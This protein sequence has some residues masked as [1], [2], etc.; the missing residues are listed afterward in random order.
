MDIFTTIGNFFRKLFKLDGVRV[1]DDSSK[2]RHAVRYDPDINVG[3]TEMQI[4]ERTEE[5]LINEKPANRTK[6]YGRII[7]ENVFNFCNTA[8]II[9]VALLFIAGAGMYAFSSI[10]V[11]LNMA[12]GI[13][14]EIK[15]KHKVEKLSMVMESR[16]DVIRD[17]KHSD[18]PNKQLALDDIY[19]LHA[20]QQ[21]PVDSVIK[22]GVVEV[23][24]SIITGESIPVRKSAGDYVLGA[25]AVVSGEA[26]L[27]ADKVG[28][29]CYIEN[30]ARVARRVSKP[31]SNI[32]S[33]L[34]KIIKIISVF[35]FFLAGFLLISL[36]VTDAES[37][38][39]IESGANLS[40]IS[41]FQGV[42]ITI[43]AAIL[44]ML[45]IG[46]FLLTSTT[47][48]ASTIKFT[49]KNTI[50]QDLYSIEMIAMVDTLLLDKTGTI[51]D[52]KLEVIDS[53][54]YAEAKY[55][56]DAVFNTILLA[57]KDGNSTANA[58]KSHFIYA[59]SLEYKDFCAF[60]SARKFSAVTLAD[61]TTY[62][63]GAPDFV[64]VNN[65][66]LD[67]YVS[68]NAEQGRRTIALMEFDGDIESF[69]PENAK[70]VCALTLEDSLRGDVKETLDWFH[71]N[72]VNIKIVSGD[73][74][75][76]VSKI[77]EK[78]G[79]RNAE[80][81]LNCKGLSD[82]ELL[83]KV[84]ETT[85][86]GRVSPEQ[87]QLIVNGLQAKG[88]TVGMIGDGVND[89]QALKEADCSISFASANEVARNI[90]RI[91]LMD[92]NFKTLPSAVQEGRQVIS[93]IQKVSSLYIMK[94]IFVM[95]MVFMFT[96][97]TFITK[98]NNYPFDT[99]RMLL[100][101]FFVI[102]VPTFCF[103]LQPNKARATDHFLANIMR[104]SI[105]SAIGLILGVMFIFI[106]LG[107]FEGDM[108]TFAT[109]Q[110][111]STA[112][113]GLAAAGFVCLIIISMPPDWFR[114]GLTVF[115]IGLAGLAIWLDGLYAE[116]LDKWFGGTFLNIQLDLPAYNWML[117]GVCAAIAGVVSLL[118]RFLVDWINKKYGEQ[119]YVAVENFNAKLKDI[120]LSAKNK[121][122]ALIKKQK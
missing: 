36:L 109:M 40:E 24:E 43:S 76:T 84:D 72:D 107:C 101:E 16:Y 118:V 1:K 59:D 29:D 35:L 103:A 108:S 65:Q 110:N 80:N 77:A 87:K 46:M 69:N 90:S 100:I 75:V 55:D 93:N 21:V 32:F 71:E 52:G 4:A 86:F 68:S 121:L 117:I 94:N 88:K 85:I 27:R 22:A 7:F 41:Q 14:Q 45:P 15:A 102:G 98:T 31:K 47:L 49:K 56:T 99:K 42:V 60:S 79:I 48:A 5:K 20:G 66:E 51:T 26:T 82:E 53:H 38:F 10:I 50:P 119:M 8:T 73:N 70:C 120:K 3:L 106:M 96:V 115:M 113:I 74:P 2:L 17:G 78:S 116:Q 105:P 30:V 9:L 18:I 64:S 6:S 91:I 112:A 25:C 58:I 39:L 61:G 83:A 111:A 89:V 44:G 13:Y 11:I 34:D 62:V 37:T 114:L 23:D 19:V 104:A 12:I 92:N 95:F 54:K 63:M 33:T 122:T 67:E 81:Y 57:T 28:K 97:L